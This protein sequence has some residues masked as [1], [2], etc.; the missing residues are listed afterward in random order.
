MLKTGRGHKETGFLT[1]AIQKNVN[2]MFRFFFPAEI[3]VGQKLE[4]KD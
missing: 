3:Y 1:S 2:S 4:A